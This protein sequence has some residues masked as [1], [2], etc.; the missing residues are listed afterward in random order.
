MQYAR[1]ILLTICSVMA[2]QDGKTQHIA[3]GEKHV[4]A[5]NTDNKVIGWGQRKQ[6]FYWNGRNDITLWTPEEVVKKKRLCRF[7]REKTQFGSLR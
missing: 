1:L 7:S 6:H 5:I 2:F 4:I 3:F